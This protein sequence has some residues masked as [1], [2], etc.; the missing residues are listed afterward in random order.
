MPAADKKQ[1]M[2]DDLKRCVEFHG[3]ICPGLIYGYRVAR[4]AMKLM[5][6]KRAVDE[7]VVAVCE[8]DSCAVDALQVLLGTAAGKGNLIIRD[9]GKNAY[10]VLSRSKRQA[11]R[12]SRK[13]HY[14][15][16]GKDKNAFDRLSAALAVGTAT[17]D[18]RRDLRRL[19]VADLLARPFTEIFTVAR[20]PFD[21]PL[22]APLAP[23]EPC[24]GC[25]EMTMAAK[26]VKL[27]DGRQ[28]CIPCSEKSCK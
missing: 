19:K 6:L 21:E 10:T 26:M 7:E 18:D 13:T 8:N 25:G 3:H 12:F 4:E 27:N 16:A 17:E 28:V 24:A 14:A 15:Y 20:V 9:F 2:P 1:Q 5:K 11:Y 23:S 22:Y